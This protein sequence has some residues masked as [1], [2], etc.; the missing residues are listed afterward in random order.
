MNRK[1]LAAVL[2][3]AAIGIAVAAT[4]GAASQAVPG[5]TPTTITLGGTFPFTGPASLL[6]H[7]C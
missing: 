3:V 4:A 5:I 7:C 2:C 1:K 6:A